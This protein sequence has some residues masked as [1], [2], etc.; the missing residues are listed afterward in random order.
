MATT[1]VNLTLIKVLREMENI[2]AIYPTQTYKKVAGNPDL[3]QKLVAYIL[4]RLPNKYITVDDEQLAENLSQNI[5]CSTWEQL[6]IEE[7]VQQGIYYLVNLGEHSE[8]LPS[9]GKVR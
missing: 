3:Q 7:L 9:S 1:M 4:N 8:F 6:E 5:A 2:L